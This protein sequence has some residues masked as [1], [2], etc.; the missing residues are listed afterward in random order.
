MTDSDRTVMH[1]PAAPFY[2]FCDLITCVAQEAK[3]RVR[4]DGIS[5]KTVDPANVSMVSVNFPPEAFDRWTFGGDCTVG[6][7]MVRLSDAVGFAHKGQGT[8]GGDPVTWTVNPQ[9]QKTAVTVDRDGLSMTERWT[10]IDP[11]NV[12][13]EP[14]I[15]DLSHNLT[16]TADP[17]TLALRDGVNYLYDQQRQHV[18]VKPDPDN[19]TTL[20]LTAEGDTGESTLSFPESVFPDSQTGQNA[21]ESYYSMDYLRDMVSAVHLSRMS[22]VTLKWGAEYPLKIAFQSE[23]WG[24]DG[25]MI[26]APPYKVRLTNQTGRV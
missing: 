8:D 24:A 26:I 14:D 23:D 2:A 3:L 13:Q 25:E 12:R 20:L 9:E 22:K 17:S 6:L 10:T 1:G 11:D 18:R 19:D 4:E 16:A 21:P 5:V 7:N 15:P